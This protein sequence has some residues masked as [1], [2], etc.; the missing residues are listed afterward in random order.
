MHRQEEKYAFHWFILMNN[1]FDS[2]KHNFD[3]FILWIIWT[4]PFG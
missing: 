3:A 2:N 1:Y 4:I